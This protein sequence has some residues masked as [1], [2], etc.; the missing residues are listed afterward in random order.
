MLK[1]SFSTKALAILAL[2][3][4]VAFTSLTTAMA[5]D[6]PQL[7]GLKQSPKITSSVLTPY[8]I[9]ETAQNE[10][11]FSTLIVALKATGLNQTLADKNTQFT[12]FAPTD[13]AF[14]KLPVGTLE[15]LLKPENKAALTKILTYH[16]VSKPLNASAVLKMKLIG[17]VEGSNL[18]V[19][20]KE[21]NPFVNDSQITKT[22]IYAT[23]GVIHV[24]DTVLMP[25]D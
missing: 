22:N 2:T 16:V 13:D 12:F 15:N 1:R 17:T 4:A 3:G 5:N 7:V 21:G 10:S 8:N 23:N 25:N 14:R 18:A 19:S 6:T 9:V 24:I 11:I 20:T